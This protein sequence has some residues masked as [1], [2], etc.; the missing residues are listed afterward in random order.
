MKSKTIIVSFIA[1]FVLA[2]ALNVVSA[3]DFADVEQVK[4]NGVTLTEG[5]NYVGKVSDTVPV[6]VEFNALENSPDHKSESYVTNARI[7]VYLENYEEETEETVYLRNTAL[8][9]GTNGY[10]ARFSLAYPSSL[11]L[12]DDE[13]F[14]DLELRVI[15][16][17][18]GEEN[19]ETSY[20][21]RISKDSESLSIL[22]VETPSEITSGSSVA[23]D[24]VVENNGR[25]RLD[26]VYVKA[27][28]P[29]LG[30]S[31]KVYIGDMSSDLDEEYDDIRDTLNKKVYLSLPRNIIPG[32]YELEVEAYNY[33]TTVKAQKTI[34][35]EDVATG[36]IPGTMTQTIAAGEEA[37][38][39][40]VLVNP[41]NR[42]TVYS[43]IS[44]STEGLI[45]EIAEPIVTVGAE[46]S[47]IVKVK[48]RATNSVEEG[49]HAIT[50]NVVSEAGSTKP[51][52]F[53][54]N[55]DDTKTSRNIGST[56]PVVIWTV[57]LV[58]VFVVLL[59]ILIVL[60][61]KRPVE[62]EEFGETSY[63]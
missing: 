8:D 62:T 54:V 19:V 39:N 43:I 29:E 56:D 27:S 35:V 31:K 10:T 49:T 14:R 2:F 55:V 52:T 34:V 26:D 5:S 4:V 17:A 18:P 47:K 38:F 20:M 60:L 61:T 9:A 42:M 30:I 22:S 44:E 41:S 3:A 57:V 24:V 63:Y 23:I 48:V 45:V 59:I 13:A 12:D 32:T 36:I 15:M 16:K 7:K 28:I 25:E 53:T 33:D 1:L 40:V 51:V 58:I 6:Y 50:V 21:I 46:S 37:T 11:E